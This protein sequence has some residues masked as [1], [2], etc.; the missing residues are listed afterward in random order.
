MSTDMNG[1]T[2]RCQALVS[3]RSSQGFTLTELLVGVAIGLIGIVAM[4]QVLA[5]WDRTKRTTAAG[6]DSQIA[7]AVGYYRLERDVKQGG[8]GFGAAQSSIMGC[9]VSAVVN[10]VAAT[11]TSPATVA[12]GAFTIPLVPVQII[13]GA[14]N[15][16]DALTVFYGNSTFFA[17]EQPFTAS[18][19]FSKKTTSRH[20]FKVGNAVVVAD[21]ASHCALIEVSGDTNADLLTLDHAGLRFNAAAGTGATFSSGLLFNLGTV[22]QLN[23]WGINSGALV[24]TDSLYANTS[25][26]VSDGVIDLQAQYGI[27]ANGD[28]KVD[29]W[30][31]AAPTNWTQLLAVRVAMLARSQQYEATRTEAGASVYVTSVAPILPWRD[32]ANNTIA[33]KMNNVDGNADSNPKTD[34]DWRNYRYRVYGGVIPLRNMV[35]G[36]SP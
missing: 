18:T 9:N 24:V 34:N 25:V 12:R 8:M 2:V 20:G 36:V 30:Q 26:T 15:D 5:L 23:V 16:P 28:Y 13:Q 14:S 35:W 4:F 33:F 29:V 11:A 32:N 19:A 27:D 7:G 31:D 3:H 22:P 1:Q 17:A 6:S 21:T 10:A